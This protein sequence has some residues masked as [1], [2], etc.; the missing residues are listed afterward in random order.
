MEGVLSEP[1]LR[2]GELARRSGVST[3]TLRAWERRYGVIEPVRGE[4]GYRLYSHADERRL[5]HMVGLIEMGIAPAEAARRLLAS[6]SPPSPTAA[7][8]V[9]PAIAAGLRGEVLAALLRFD[10]TEADQLLDRAVSILS[11]EA[12]L[13]DLILPVLR[14]IGSGW[15]NEEVTIGQEHFASNVLRGRMLGLARGWGGGEGRLALLAAPSGEHHDLGLIAF[16]LALRSRGW[17]VAFLGADTPVAS[18]ISAAEET[19]PAVSVISVMDP[20][21]FDGIEL[22]LARLGLVTRL[23]LAGAGVPADLA[24]RIGATHMHSDPVLAAESLAV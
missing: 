11:I 23:M 7:V 20:E 13:T 6:P 18:V 12:L 10:E 22:D 21:R 17:R 16:G 14:D 9:D 8:P 4:S 3:A 1:L 5:Q 2:I 15:Q 19:Q 24:T